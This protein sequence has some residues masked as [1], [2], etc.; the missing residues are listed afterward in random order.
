MSS[1]IESKEETRLAQRA[2]FA[3][4]R[5]LFERRLSSEDASILREVARPQEPSESS[6]SK[7][8]KSA[9]EILLKTL[10]P[11]STSTPLASRANRT[12]PT[13]LKVKTAFTFSYI[14]LPSPSKSSKTPTIQRSLSHLP[15]VF[16]DYNRTSISSTSSGSLSPSLL[17]SDPGSF[18]SSASSEITVDE[19]STPN[20]PEIQLQG[21]RSSISS[22]KISVSDSQYLPP[23]RSITN[24]LLSPRSQLMAS[25][26]SL[27]EQWESE[28]SFF[29]KTAR[30]AITLYYFF[31]KSTDQH[32]SEEEK[33][34]IL[35][36]INQYIRMIHTNTGSVKS[37]AKRFLEECL[38]H[39]YFEEMLK[40]IHHPMPGSVSEAPHQL[41]FEKWMNHR[42]FSSGEE[43]KKFVDFLARNKF[44]FSGIFQKEFT[45][46]ERQCVTMLLHL[47]T[48]VH[49]SNFSK[50]S[51]GKSYFLVSRRHPSC[52]DGDVY[53]LIKKYVDDKTKYSQISPKR[54]SAFNAESFERIER[55]QV[56][57]FLNFPNLF[58]LLLR[59][60][61]YGRLNSLYVSLEG[62]YN[63]LQAIDQ[64]IRDESSVRKAV[65]TMMTP[66]T[67]QKFFL[68]DSLQKNLESLQISLNTYTPKILIDIPP[69]GFLPWLKELRSKAR[70]LPPIQSAETPREK[71]IQR[72]QRDFAIPEEEIAY[73]FFSNTALKDI[74]DSKN[75]SKNTAEANAILK[76]L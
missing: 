20:L 14:E 61:E 3:L 25:Q 28:P 10:S 36:I 11:K 17:E 67:L 62:F 45:E 73:V 64:L 44:I 1:P 30:L 43:F 66:E 29:H 23:K 56:S 33:R 40:K 6:R 7:T 76:S 65:E 39:A 74:F 46:R 41:V 63:F 35:A 19:S 27:L 12:P 69:C 47:F 31:P 50:D 58:Q 49:Q 2:S 55:I 15:D 24:A 70:S 54:G 71:I 75:D 51:L 72:L 18:R 9:Q 52:T 21:A 26:K 22:D 5:D 48:L 68:S 53:G 42:I 32:F 60:V 38:D 4:K 13:P 57:I 16:V 34:W 37:I 59:S 8:I